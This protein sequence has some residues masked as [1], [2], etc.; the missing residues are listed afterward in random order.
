MNLGNGTKQTMPHA[1]VNIPDAI[2]IPEEICYNSIL[3]HNE[4]EKRE[5]ETSDEV[6]CT[7]HVSK[8]R[9]FEF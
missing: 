3:L 5:S 6:I 7:L 9:N 4:N 8:S 2:V 1:M